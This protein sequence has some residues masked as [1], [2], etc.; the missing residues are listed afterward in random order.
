[1]EELRAPSHTVRAFASSNR[2][3]ARNTNR[4]AEAEPS[5]RCALPLTRRAWDPSIRR[6]AIRLINL[7][8]Y[9]FAF[10]RI[11]KS[12]MVRTGSHWRASGT[13]SST[14]TSGA[15]DASQRL[16]VAGRSLNEALSR[17]DACIGEEPGIAS[18]P[19]M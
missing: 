4:L 5:M 7:Q 9:R 2:P 14:P 13:T 17:P 16:G 8:R 12:G 6:S 10:Q 15:F 1:M 11:T 19:S 18:S 3:A